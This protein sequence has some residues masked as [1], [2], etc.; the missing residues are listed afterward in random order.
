LGRDGY[1]LSDDEEVDDEQVG[2]E[3]VVEG[4]EIKRCGEV[5]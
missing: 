4:G 3:Q 2:K 1:G 5:F